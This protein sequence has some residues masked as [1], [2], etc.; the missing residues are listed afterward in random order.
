MSAVNRIFLSAFAFCRMST[1]AC[2]TLSQPCV[3]HVVCWSSFPSVSALP[4][5]CSAAVESSPTLFADFAGTILL[6]D[7]PCPCIIGLP[8]QGSRCGPQLDRRRSNVGSPSSVA[9]S[10]HTC[11]GVEDVRAGMYDPIRVL[12]P[13]APGTS[14]IWTESV[15]G[16]G[17]LEPPCPQKTN[18]P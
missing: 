14:A 11:L 1:S 3:W 18:K 10:F 2:C 13:G 16:L 9:R 5:I 15:F 6:S 12:P 4:S 17:P 8:L 7:F